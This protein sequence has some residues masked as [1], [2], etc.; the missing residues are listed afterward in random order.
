M[1][2]EAAQALAQTSCSSL[3]RRVA[4]GYALV[5]LV[6]GA[7]VRRYA[8][9]GVWGLSSRVVA[10]VA[11]LGLAV[12]CLPDGGGTVARAIVLQAGDY[13]LAADG[14]TDDGPAIRRLLRAAEAAPGPV[15]LVFPEARTIRV[16]TA[17]DR[18]VFD[19]ARRSDWRIDG[20]G[21]VFLLEPR[22]RFARVR[23]C[24]RT[25][26]RGVRVDYDP[27]AFADGTVVAMDPA[28]AWVEVALADP[29]SPLPLGGG[30]GE[31]GE[32]AFFGMLWHEGPYGLTSTH[33]WTDRIEAT[34]EPRIVRAYATPEFGAWGAVVPG[35]TRISLP[36]PGIAHRYGPGPCFELE[37]NQDLALEDVELWS[38]PWFGFNVSRNAG[39]VTFRRVHI[40][41]K[42]GTGRLTST[43]RD[44]FH[45]KGNR[46]SLL[47]EDCVLEGMNDDA[48]NVS[49][50]SS[51]VTALPSEGCIEVAQRFPLLPIP[52][53][54]GAVLRAADEASG[55]LLGVATVVSAVPGPHPPPIEGRPAAPT[56]LLTLDRSIP[57]LG[58]GAM[59]WDPA[60]CNPD[61]T[62]RRCTIRMSCRLQSPVTL[63]EC[64]VTALLWFYAESIE[65]GFPHHV[66]L[67]DC[68]LRRGRGNPEHAVVFSGGAGDP[69][70][71]IHDVELRGNTIAGG[72]R[73]DGVGGLVL[74]ENRF[75][76]EGAPMLV[77]G[78]H[79]VVTR[80]NLD[81]DGRPGL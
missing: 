9:S 73:I 68:R 50:H 55:R 74:D 18:Y 53:T 81:V 45:V 63:E 56:Y 79:D 25:E 67:L 13:G 12:P 2:P 60:W 22:L 80:G 61:T 37:D 15:S 32:Q 28:E 48:F 20:G 51:R 59:V 72:L 39:T 24:H 69:P 57:E 46:G 5:S 47:W 1:P 36:V 77:E 58:V 3:D 62:L 41:P 43:W 70:R 16:L 6:I 27:L 11:C 17:P 78:C 14:V 40:R 71:A 31:D 35:R 7:V 76:E 33:Y 10:A 38:A 21:S 34:A 8:A 75:V 29:A 49:T 26:I 54:D 4:V 19:L 64:D 23:Q 42:P 65:G 52:W 30:T 66:R 44:G